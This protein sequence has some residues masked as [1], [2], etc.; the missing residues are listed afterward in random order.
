M[1]EPNVKGKKWNNIPFTSLSHN[2]QESMK[3]KTD[4]TAAGLD[5]MVHFNFVKK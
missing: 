2:S 5:G 3:G 1:N 4:S